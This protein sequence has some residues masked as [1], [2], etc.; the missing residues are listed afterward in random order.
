LFFF[1]LPTSFSVGHVHYAKRRME[2]RKGKGKKERKRR[3]RKGELE[4]KE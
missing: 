3:G 1:L 4:N 2:K